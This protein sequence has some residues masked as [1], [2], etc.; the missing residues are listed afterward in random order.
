MTCCC[1]RRQS[2]K[3]PRISFWLGRKSTFSSTRAVLGTRLFAGSWL[4]SNVKSL[5]GAALAGKGNFTEAKP[6]LVEGYEGLRNA[7]AIPTKARGET[8]AN[9]LQRLVD[10]NAAWDKS[11]EAAKWQKLLDEPNKKIE[12]SD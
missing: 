9:S 8:L 1:V 10:L 7:D 6:L 5:L 4:E 12:E 2:T 3:T 11:D